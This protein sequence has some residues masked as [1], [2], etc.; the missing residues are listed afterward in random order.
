LVDR[1]RLF[2]GLWGGLALI[3]SHTASAGLFLTED[4]VQDFADNGVEVWYDAEKHHL[5]PAPDGPFSP[6]G[7]ESAD[8]G[9]ER[10]YLA[11]EVAAEGTPPLS[12]DIDVRLNLEGAG[13]SG[14][15]QQ[16]LTG[17]MESMRHRE[18][19]GGSLEYLVKGDRVSGDLSNKYTGTGMYVT[20]A[21]LSGTE[22]LRFYRSLRNP[23][24]A[25]GTDSSR[26]D[27]LLAMTPTAASAPGT[28]PLMMV[29]AGIGF[30]GLRGRSRG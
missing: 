30:L 16:T 28:L 5:M 22:W 8:A 21:G 24:V 1:L 7:R 6:A 4:T 2:A 17:A 23:V 3:A 11:G 27:T 9:T 20:V 26:S 12:F 29:A 14:G 13:L 18:A 25:Q 19:H 10:L 15:P